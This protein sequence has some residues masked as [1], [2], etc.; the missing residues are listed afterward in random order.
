MPRTSKKERAA[1]RNPRRRGA[2]DPET[3]VEEIPFTTPSG[4]TITI[5]RTNQRDA[6]DPPEE[7]PERPKKVKR[8]SKKKA[9]GKRDKR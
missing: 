4:E 6:Y 7:E 1:P 5:L 3:V 8:T 2:P 9:G